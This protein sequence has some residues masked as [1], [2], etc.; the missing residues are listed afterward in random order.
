[1][2][3]IKIQ[4]ENGDKKGIFTAVENEKTVGEMIYTWLSDNTF[5][6]THTE[7]M[8]GNEGK[9]IGKLL[10]KSAVEFARSNNLKIQPECSFVAA[11]FNK[12]D[13]Y[14]DVK[15]TSL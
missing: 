8:K 6:I 10:L 9:G 15:N 13:D 12:S 14:N 4:Q 5:V 7:V 11:A 1:M 3:D 2:N